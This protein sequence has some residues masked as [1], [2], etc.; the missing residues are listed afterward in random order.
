MSDDACASCSGHCCY[1]MIVRVNGYDAW[2]IAHAQR[3]PYP[4]F[5]MIG[6][7]A[8]GT[9]YGFKLAGRPGMHSF[10]LRRSEHSEACTFLV[11]ISEETKRCG[12][13]AD[14][15]TVCRVYPMHFH[16]GAVAMRDDVRCKPTDFTM[17]A[18]D[19][20]H[21]RSLLLDFHCEWTMYGWALNVWNQSVEKTGAGT[22]EDFTRFI[23]GV[24]T[25]IDGE[26]RRIA[27]AGDPSLIES[28]MMMDA[29]AEVLE[30]RNEFS[31]LIERVARESL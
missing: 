22:E 17:A 24:F 9:G 8:E 16:H 21:W 4:N 29:P 3:I 25:R 7:D 26:C 2:R 14:R 11:H 6:Q 18:L 15:P 30:R 10:Y 23:D 19:V 12:I 1:D 13:Y 28:W 27:E 31:A 20:G 5:V